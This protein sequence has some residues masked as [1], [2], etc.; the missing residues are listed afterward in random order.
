MGWHDRPYS[1]DDFDGGPGGQMRLAMPRPT[2]AVMWLLIA[3]VAAY[4]VDVLTQHLDPG[5]WPEVFGLSW[6]GV[7]GGYFWQ[8]VTYMFSH[9]D[10]WHLVFNMIGLYIFGMH[11]ER[12]F[13]RDRFLK[14][15]AICGLVSAAAYLLASVIGWIPAGLPV[16]GAS[17][18]IYGLLIAAIIFFPHIQIIFIIFPMPIRVFGLIV[19]GMLLLRL[20]SPGPMCNLGGEI[21]HIAGALGGVATL[22]LWRMTPRVGVVDGAVGGVRSRLAKGAWERRMRREAQ[23]QQEV[24]RI[25]AKVGES[26]IQSLTRKER[27]A[28]EQATK[29]QQ[30]RNANTGRVD[31]L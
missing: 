29:R 30:H 10:P 16:V 28:L 20:I 27:K 25:L 9:G 24:D 19:A 4:F 2:T 7:T 12:T 23:E 6:S 1:G 11:F 17:G 3:N 26:G 18:A 8:P 21:C 15:Y 22:Y 13:G 14:F 5:F 31:R